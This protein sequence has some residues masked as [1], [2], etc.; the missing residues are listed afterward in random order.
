MMP[1]EVAIDIAFK[2]ANQLGRKIEAIER[3][4]RCMDGFSRSELGMLRRF[5][6][7]AGVSHDQLPDVPFVDPEHLKKFQE[8]RDEARARRRASTV[9]EL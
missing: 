6:F 5:L 4:T 2:R 7:D 9:V 3:N 1:I 8:N